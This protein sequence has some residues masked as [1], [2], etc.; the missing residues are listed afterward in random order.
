MPIEGATVAVMP[1]LGL[2]RQRFSPLYGA[3][4]LRRPQ[5]I[6]VKV[7]DPALDLLGW[8]EDHLDRIEDAAR[9]KT[10]T[11]LSEQFWKG[12]DRLV[13]KCQANPRLHVQI[14][15]ADKHSA[16]AVRPIGPPTVRMDAA[17][18]VRGALRAVVG[19]DYLDREQ[20]MALCGPVNRLRVKL[21]YLPVLCGWN[22]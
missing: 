9:A 4:P 13:E 10:F 22:S 16:R 7:D 6:E 3:H 8:V 14:E 21:G 15:W 5:L 1:E 18:V 20:F 12:Y 2:N 17:N 11:L 19:A